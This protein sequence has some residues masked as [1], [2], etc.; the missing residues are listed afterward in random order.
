MATKIVQP[1][2]LASQ[3][4]DVYN[5][6]TVYNAVNAT[7]VTNGVRNTDDSYQ[8]LYKA[9]N[10]DDDV[11]NLGGNIIEQKKELYNNSTGSSSIT[12]DSGSFANGD[13]L[14]LHFSVATKPNNILRIQLNSAGASFVKSET[15][16]QNDSAYAEIAINQVSV[17]ITIA[18][19]TIAVLQ[20]IT[21]TY[22]TTSATPSSGDSLNFVNC[23]TYSPS[24][25]IKKIYKIV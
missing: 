17:I 11:L 10:S 15:V 7:N 12:L 5:D 22:Q 2:V 24:N 19:Q 1:K 25:A 16:I 3:S 21:N 14:E 18:T 4:P 20:G 13:I 6:L 8:R 23:S 9:T